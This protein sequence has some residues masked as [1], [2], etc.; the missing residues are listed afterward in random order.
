M[1]RSIL[2]RLLGDDKIYKEYNFEGKYGKYVPYNARDEKPSIE[3]LLDK[4]DEKL[5]LVLDKLRKKARQNKRK[6]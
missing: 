5:L 1:A 4:F 3:M 6:L 2:N